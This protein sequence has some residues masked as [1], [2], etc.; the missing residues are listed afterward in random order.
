[1]K[2]LIIGAVYSGNGYTG[3]NKIFACL[4][5]P[6]LNM[7]MFKKYEREV[8]SAIENATNESCQKAAS[9]ERQLVIENIEKL[10]EI[11]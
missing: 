11:L 6:E 5:I 2:Y 1:M 4:D 10:S 7:K 3:L 9:E 8:G